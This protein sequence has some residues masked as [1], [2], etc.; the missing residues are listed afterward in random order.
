MYDNILCLPQG[1]DTEASECG[2]VLP[3][4][5]KQ[6]ISTVRALLLEAKILVPDDALSAIDGRT[7]HQILHNLRRWG[8]GWTVITSAR[9]LSALTKISEILVL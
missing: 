1:Y 6:R 9:R 5:Q 3:G 4:G 7:E 8:E 2:V